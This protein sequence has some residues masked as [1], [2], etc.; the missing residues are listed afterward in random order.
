MEDMDMKK[1]PKIEMIDWTEHYPNESPLE[2]AIR[3]S[4]Y[5]PCGKPKEIGQANCGCKKDK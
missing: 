2:I 1:Q 3:Q 4:T 5:C